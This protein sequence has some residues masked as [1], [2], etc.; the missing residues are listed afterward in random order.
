MS[1][2]PARVAVW[3]GGD[4][5]EIE[6]VPLPEPGEG[7]L[8]VRVGLATIC[9]SDHH[10]VSGRRP[11]PCPSV[12][13]HEGVGRVVAAGPGAGVRVGERVV[14]SV[15][16]SC[17]RCDRCLAGRTAK[18]RSVRKI[19]HEPYENGWRLSGTYASHLLLPAGTAVVPVPAEMPDAVASPA[20]CATGTVMAALEQAGNLAGRRVLVSGA[21]MLGLTAIAAAADGRAAQVI[22]VDLDRER[23]DLAKAFGAT[24][25][26]IAGDR[27]P[28]VDVA[29]DFSGSAAA[30]D[31]ALAALDIGGVLVLVGSVSPGPAVSLDPERLVRGWQRIAGVH[32]YEPRHL[33]QAVAFL[34]ASDR[35]WPDLVE[36]PVPLDELT[37]ALTTTMPRP[38]AAVRP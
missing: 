10:T 16:V 13:G 27:L 8:L 20:G 34:A 17:G 6:T 28:E 30:V 2:G 15:T 32:N 24:D 4:R 22:A 9:G 29:L 25:M 23:L 3:R 26:L 35:P 7:E 1:A 12:L 37:H 11:G 31:A 33:E 19:G 5:I 18:C 36:Q 38:R 14:W 21:G